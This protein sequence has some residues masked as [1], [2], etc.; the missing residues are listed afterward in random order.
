MPVIGRGA[1]AMTLALVLGTSA[2]C[3]DR[4][5]IVGRPTLDLDQ[6]DLVAEVE[7][8][9]ISSR[10]I[11]LRENNGRSRVVTYSADARVLYRGREYPVTQLEAG[12]LVAMQ[13]I[14]DSRGNSSTELVRVQESIGERRQNQ[15]RGASTRPEIGM[16]TVDGTVERVDLLRNWFEI[17]DPRGERIFVS[18]P[19]S[20]REAAIDRFRALHPGDYVKVEGRFLEHDQFEL[21]AFL[22]DNL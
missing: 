21:T 2:G 16:E 17:R 8:V 18:L 22:R 7:R 4:I 13:L 15:N 11:Y 19:G 10:S 3:M 12:D 1:A 6:Q 20:A 9:D 14:Q 5:A